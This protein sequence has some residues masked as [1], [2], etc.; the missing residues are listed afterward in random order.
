[1][2]DKRKRVGFEDDEEEQPVVKNKPIILDRTIQ[3][4]SEPIDFIEPLLQRPYPIK[5]TEDDDEPIEGIHEFNPLYIKLEPLSPQSAVVDDYSEDAETSVPIP[6]D[7]IGGGGFIVTEKQTAHQG[8]LSTITL[9]PKKQSGH[10]AN[11]LGDLAEPITEHITTLLKR[12]R[13]LKVFLVLDVDYQSITDAANQ[14][15]DHLHT[16]FIPVFSEI[17]IPH[18]LDSLNQELVLKNENFIKFKSGLVLKNISKI[19]MSV[20]AHQPL[21]G[22]QFQNLPP[23]LK[24]K[25]CIVNV[26]NKDNRCFGYALLAHLEPA[27]NQHRLCEE[28]SYKHLFTKYHLDAIQYPVQPAD[29]PAIEGNLPYAINVFS[30]NDDLGQSR[31]PIYVSPKTDTPMI[32]LLYWNE[33]YALIKDF[34][35]FMFDIT[36]HRNPKN[37][38][39][40]CFGHFW[41]EA[42]LI[43][44]QKFCL[45]FKGIKTNIRMPPENSVCEFTNIQNQLK[46]PFAIYADFECLLPQNPNQEEVRPGKTVQNQKHVPFAVGFKLI[47]PDLR[48]AANQ[49]ASLDF[50][51]FPYEHHTGKHCAEWFL[52]RMMKVESML[53]KILFNDER[54]VMTEED[55]AAFEVATECH[56]CKKGWNLPEPQRRNPAHASENLDS[57]DNDRE[58]DDKDDEQEEYEDQEELAQLTGEEQPRKAKWE[59]VRDHDHLT[60]KFRGAAHNFC[61]LRYRKQFK[62][63]VLFHNL[64]NYD[65]HL[66]VKAM[67]RFPKYAINPIAQGL[68]KYLIIGWGKHLV[69]K[70]SLQFMATSLENLG[71]NLLTKG[72]EHFVHLHREFLNESPERMDLILRKGVYPYDFM[73]NWSR[74]KLRVLPSRQHFFNN[75]KQ[76]EC[77]VEDYNHARTVWR[78]F[79]CANMQDYTDLYLKTDVLILADVFEAFRE[80]G[81]GNFELDPIHYLSAPQFSW[82]AMLKK[83]QVKAQLISD[84]AMY[85]MI[86]S[87]IRGGICMISQRR[88]QANHKRM[89]PLYNPTLPKKTITYFDANNLYGYA[90]S[91]PIPISGFCWMDKEFW[92]KAKDWLELDPNSSIGY[93]VECDLQYPARIHD[94][95]NEYPLAPERV[96]IETE[97][98][99]DTQLEIRM[100]YNISQAQNTKLI[101]HLG[102]RQHYVLHSSALRFYMENGM[103]LI[104]VH[105][106]IQFLQEPWMKPYVDLCSAL[107]AKST[108]DFEKNFFKIMVNSVY[109]KTVEN[110]SKRTNIKIVQSREACK[111]L[112]VKPQCIGFRIFSEHLAA[113]QL[114]KPMCLINKPFYVGFSVLDISK[115]CYFCLP[116]FLFDCSFEIRD[117]KLSLSLRIFT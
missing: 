75:L 61:N 81:M 59:K 4:K 29:I 48:T 50:N 108:N 58:I 11:T 39:R 6:Q 116:I 15:S 89:G 65:S 113:V 77:S 73:R 91:Q 36:K 86:S 43:Q 10:L 27:M 103:E 37:F 92:P 25:K 87:G 69:F 30:F 53:L 68:E 63:P 28:N 76:S 34:N 23:F 54:M 107:R 18:L 5:R 57:D 13:G 21:A 60:G 49:D 93:V 1:M 117:L 38:C 79:H 20:A 104:R 41:K 46:C 26:K 101:P 109:G 88:A 112:T 40:R 35:R 3:I 72:R 102:D 115:V 71:A 85:E 32:D 74:L 45:G 51:N 67:E 110:Q 14:V 80:M 97:M 19:T 82:D 105:R 47:G 55:K 66:I 52:L 24:N 9:V 84:P 44:H 22:S 111:K 100:H 7:Q 33:H 8:Y 96:A 90:M 64:K 17:E 31:F 83:T 106:V 12:H 42:T 56:I 99:S 78:E 98:L 95:H 114:R 16:H 62:I 2:A 70:D 94:L